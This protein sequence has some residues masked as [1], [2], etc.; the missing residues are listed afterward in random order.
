M[1]CFLC[2]T[3]IIGETI[4]KRA[5]QFKLWWWFELAGREIV[6][7]LLLYVCIWMICTVHSYANA[8]QWNCG[9]IIIIFGTVIR[10]E[11][12]T[13]CVPIP[14]QRHSTLCTT[15]TVLCML[16]GSLL[17]TAPTIFTEDITASIRTSQSSSFCQ[18]LIIPIV[19]QARLFSRL[20]NAM[21]ECQPKPVYGVHVLGTV[22]VFNL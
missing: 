10:T 16:T 11:C 8:I 19:A 22:N 5:R 15:Q 20:R 7:Q 18:Q 13:S 9:I 2:P 14:I 12:K 4:E 3:R 1:H 6:L 21:L 17:V